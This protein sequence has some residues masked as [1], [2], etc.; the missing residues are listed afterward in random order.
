MSRES[1]RLYDGMTQIEDDVIEAAQKPKRRRRA[2]WMAP[3]AVVLALAI[4]AGVL[5][6]RGGL[7]AYAVA[8][9]VYPEPKDRRGGDWD[10]FSQQAVTGF[11]AASIPR[12]LTGLGDGNRI[13]SP[14]TLYMGLSML[15][16]V[17][18]GET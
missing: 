6:G 17:T 1:E 15:A 12:F 18:A 3:V 11:A 13:Y 10:T 14:L 5:N 7:R 16:E 8:E 4:L 2:F 9:A